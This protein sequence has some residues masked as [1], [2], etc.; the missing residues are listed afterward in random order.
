VKSAARIGYEDPMRIVVAGTGTEIGKTHVSCALAR[1]LARSQP[2][3]ALKPVESG[4]VEDARAL[5]AACGVASLPFH[6]L[7]EPISPHLAAR[8]EGRAIALEPIRRWVEER[9]RSQPE[10]VTTLIETAGGLFSPLGP[11]LSNADLARALDP[12]ALLLVAPDRLGVLHDVAATLAAWRDAAVVVLSAPEHP[13]A[14]TGTN[15]AELASLGLADVA[16]VFPRAAI[17]ASEAEA[18]AAR[19]ARVVAATAGG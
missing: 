11:G 15:A 5:S 4:G 19:L 16:A 10:D 8:R 7:G 14:S 2:V 9:E 1:H 13:D 12:D 18:A 17:D 3:L 6:A